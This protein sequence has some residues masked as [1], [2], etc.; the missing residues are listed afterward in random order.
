MIKKKKEIKKSVCKRTRLVVTWVRIYEILGLQISGDYRNR[1][2][3]SQATRDQN[4]NCAFELLALLVDVYVKLVLSLQSKWRT[5]A[6]KF[7]GTCLR[8]CRLPRH[9]HVRYCCVA[10]FSPKYL[11]TPTHVL[12]LHCMPFTLDRSYTCKHDTTLFIFHSFSDKMTGESIR[13]YQRA[14]RTQFVDH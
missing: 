6:W 7:C 10:A 4:V 8:D 5:L 13:Y 1:R 9:M 2:I 11:Y 3:S 12:I 14:Y